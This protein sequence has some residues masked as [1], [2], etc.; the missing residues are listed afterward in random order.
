M[1]KNVPPPLLP[2]KPNRPK[3]RR[4]RKVLV[5]FA[6]IIALL[7]GMYTFVVYT[8]IPA[9]KNL[10][11]AYIET[12]MLTLNH[13]WL[14]EFF[15]PQD[16]IDEVM[17]RVVDAEES[18]AGI[19]S[20]WDDSKDSKAEQELESKKDFFKLFSELDQTS[21][22]QYVKT[23]PGVTKSGWDKIYINEAGID[24]DGTS[25]KTTQGDQVLA[26]DAKNKILIVRVKGSGYQGVLAI[27]RILPAALLSFQSHRRLRRV[28]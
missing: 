16:M 18:Q 20:K 13:H 11:E 14:A 10:R 15:F 17:S 4:L 5:T 27:A 12:A 28:P 9:I 3:N 23:N 21:F 1:K 24:D 7:L 6:C 25:I 8:N 26:V 2:S 22:E 19:I